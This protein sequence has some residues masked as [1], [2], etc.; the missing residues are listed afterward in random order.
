MLI[1]KKNQAV[2]VTLVFVVFLALAGCGASK[3]VVKSVA[4]KE[5]FPGTGLKIKG[6]D[7]DKSQ[8]KSTVHLGSKTVTASS[9]SATNISASVP[10]D[11]A[12]GNYSITVTTSGGTSNKVS[13][14]VEPSFTGSS[15]QPAMMNYLKSKGVDTTGMSFSV[16]ATSK[17]DP[18]WKLD[19]ATGASQGT[20]YFLFHKDSGGWAI[21][22][23]GTN[24][25]ADQLKADG[26]PS[27]IPPTQPAG[28]SSSSPTS[29]STSK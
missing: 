1:M 10:K 25:T 21:V 14:T 15:P 28:S 12:A 22:D 26:A 9:W 16:V 6:T 23:Y 13:F 2:V 24:L 3:P 20:S 4:P 19:K 7:F 8:G 18:N 17:T 11:M 29:P 27:D 5:G